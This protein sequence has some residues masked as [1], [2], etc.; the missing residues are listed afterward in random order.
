MLVAA[1][2]GSPT[3][4][5]ESAYEKCKTGTPRTGS[6]CYSPYI[7]ATKLSPMKAA[8]ILTLLLL[9]SATAVFAQ[10]SVPRNVSYMEAGGAGLFGSINYERQL[11]KEPGVSL[12]AGVGFYTEGAFY[13]TIPVGINYLFKFN[14]KNRFI[15]TGMTA[16]FA[17]QNGEIFRN[18]L[19]EYAHDFYVV[20]SVGYREHGANKI[21]WRVSL[22]AVVHKDATTPW[23]GFAIGKLF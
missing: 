9:I 16:T 13:L 22:A 19:P 2:A 17:R 20:P 8:S 23:V 7:Y 1:W 11:G 10:E 18:E 3:V 21:M 14:H 15:E 6:I 12:R 4:L 5:K